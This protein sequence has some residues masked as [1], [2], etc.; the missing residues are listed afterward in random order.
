[1][2]RS[3]YREAVEYFEQALS[4]LP[5]L[6]EQ[7]Q[8]IEQA[9]DLRIVLRSALMSSGE[10]GRSLTYL[11]EAEILAATL[12][13]SRR[14]AQVAGLLVVH[15]R[16]MGAYDQAIAA[17]QRALALTM[18]GEERVQHALVH[19][20]LGFAYHGQGAYRRAIDAFE[21]TVAGLDAL[22]SHERFGLPILPAVYARAWL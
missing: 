9:I 17:G 10:V 3:A 14:L 11:H 12:A 8:T 18:A 19:H 6:P 15:F 5:H 4:A 1:M 13:D 16:V 22:Q 7:R 2:A 20:Y 21:Q